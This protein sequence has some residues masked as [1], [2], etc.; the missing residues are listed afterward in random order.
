MCRA[1]TS[2]GSSSGSTTGVSATRSG[3]RSGWIR[4]DGSTAGIRPPECGNWSGRSSRTEARPRADTL[5]HVSSPST[6][7]RVALLTLGCAR[8]EVDSEE[9]A[10]RLTADGWQLVDPDEGGADVVLVN[11][12]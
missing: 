11:T 2:A 4:A 10:G 8:N 5:E 1:T 3:G 12:C 9:M 7:R 6:S